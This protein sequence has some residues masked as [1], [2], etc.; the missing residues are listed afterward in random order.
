MHNVLMHTYLSFLTSHMLHSR[1]MVNL[2]FHPVIPRDEPESRGS[3][4]D[5]LSLGTP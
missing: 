5:N 4:F 3:S 1:T 2:S